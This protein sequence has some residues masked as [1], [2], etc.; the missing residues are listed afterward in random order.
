MAIQCDGVCVVW[1]IDLPT[2]VSNS[3]ISGTKHHA[4]QLTVQ[5]HVGNLTRVL[6]LDFT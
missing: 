2:Q 1:P 6:L 5:E 4:D 3:A